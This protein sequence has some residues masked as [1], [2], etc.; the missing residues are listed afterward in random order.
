MLLDE[1]TSSP[2]TVELLSEPSSIDA[3]VLVAGCAPLIGLL[4]GRLSQRYQAARATWIR[5]NSTQALDLLARGMVHIAG[6]HLAD[7]ADPSLHLRAAQRIF[8]KQRSTVINLA[9][10]QQ[11][12]VVA[13][14]NPLNISPGPA[15]LR[16]EL[17]YVARDA[18]AAAQ[19][20]LERMVRDAGGAMPNSCGF[21]VARGHAEVAQLVR[22]GVADVGVAIEAAALA[23]QVDFVP[24]AEERF[25][26][27]V[28]SFRL[29]DPNIARFIDLLDRP[30]FRSEAAGLRGYDLT[31]A[32]HVATVDA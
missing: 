6:V 8:P 25:D 26:L 4:A 5:A 14:G 1:S 10:W 31:Y 16:N 23:E 3:H 9:R 28:P 15:L 11:G 24:C 12:L 19:H 32:G 17:R 18:G 29:E 27:I 7:A 20:L 22:W 2:A 13:S 21:P 30:A